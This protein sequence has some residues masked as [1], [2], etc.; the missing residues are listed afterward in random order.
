MSFTPRMY[1]SGELYELCF[2]ARKGFPLPPL[3]TINKLIKSA[4]ART[5]RDCKVHICHFVWMANH[6]HILIIVIDADAA[7][8]FYSELM[9]RL[10]DSVKA[11]TGKPYLNLWQTRPVVPVIGNIEAAK[12]K[13][14]YIYANPSRANLVNTIEH[15]PGYSSFPQFIQSIENYSNAPINN[16]SSA[17]DAPANATAHTSTYSSLLTLQIKETVHWIQSSHIPTLPSASL[18]EQQDKFFADKLNNPISKKG[19]RKTQKKHDLILEPNLWLSCFGDYSNED[20]IR[21]NKEILQD[22]KHSE[23]EYAEARLK[24]NKTIIGTQRLK[25]LAVMADYEPKRDPNDR[26]IIVIC[27]DKELRIQLIKRHKEFAM[28]CRLRY[29]QWSTGDTSEPWPPAGFRPPMPIMA[30]AIN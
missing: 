7:K 3:R 15:Y 18:S 20:V 11:L 27:S 16:S 29:T 2:K 17:A 13:I 5:Q 23:S 30:N 10:T 22:L 26:R 14:A 19:N 6:C 24:A 9:K 4:L 28:L 1:H 12:A 25:Q 21:I 8:N